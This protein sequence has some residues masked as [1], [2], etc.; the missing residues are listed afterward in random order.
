MCHRVIATTVC[1]AHPKCDSDSGQG[2][3]ACLCGGQPAWLQGNNIQPNQVV[4]WYTDHCTYRN[5]KKKGGWFS[6]SWEATM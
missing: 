5:I 2:R 3:S 6:I 1:R 4:R